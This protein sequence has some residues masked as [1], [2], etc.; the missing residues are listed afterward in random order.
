LKQQGLLVDANF[1]CTSDLLTRK[2]MIESS[3]ILFP[4]KKYVFFADTTQDFHDTSTIPDL[5]RVGLTQHSLESANGLEAKL[6]QSGAHTTLP[7][8]SH[9]TREW[10]FNQCSFSKGS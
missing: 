8:L 1:C 10:V 4:A 2:R 3:K 5:L 6:I 9:A 7:T